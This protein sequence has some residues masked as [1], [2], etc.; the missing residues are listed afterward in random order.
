[1]RNV[2]IGYVSAAVE[3]TLAA[4]VLLNVVSLSSEQ[5]A[6]ILV[7]VNANLALALFLNDRIDA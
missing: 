4:L 7:A 1:M 5:L 6:G 2:T 3:A